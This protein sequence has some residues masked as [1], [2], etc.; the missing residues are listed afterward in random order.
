MSKVRRLAFVVPRFEPVSAGGAEVLTRE[1]ARRLIA[2]GNEVEIFTT[3]ARNHFTWQN[4]YEE[5]RHSSDGLVIN[6]FRVKDGR[7]VD[8][9]LKLQ[10]LIDRGI[11]LSTSEEKQWISESVTSPDLVNYL[12]SNKNNFDVFFLIPYLFGL[13]YFTSFFAPEKT[14]LIPCLHDEGF[15]RLG[16]FRDMFNRV[17][18]VM[19]NAYPEQ[20][21]AEKL[22]G[23]PAEK[24]RVAGLGFEPGAG[25]NSSLFQNK[26]GIEEPF[27]LF[28]G[29]RERGKNIH[30]LIEYFNCYKLNNPGDLKLVLLGTG[31]VDL[32][33]G[34][35][36]IIDLGYI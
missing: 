14:V 15:A 2:K 10:S 4:Y 1:F 31:E 30:V 18:G 28:A 26:F 35:K 9:F 23:L 8:L 19:F 7:N 27:I 21:L 36:D 29:R 11:Q 5:G 24:G 12:E 25:Y 17:K 22:M 6:R 20:V 13:T 32:P 16:I 3:C 34:T 33:A